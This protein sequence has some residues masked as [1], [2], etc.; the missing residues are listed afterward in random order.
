MFLI[1]LAWQMMRFNEAVERMRA[2]TAIKAG[3]Q[4]GEQK[5][6]EKRLQGYKESFAAAFQAQSTQHSTRQAY[7][8]WMHR[9]YDL[10]MMQLMGFS[11]AKPRVR[12]QQWSDQEVG[13]M[14]QCLADLASG[15]DAIHTRDPFYYISHHALLRQKSNEEVKALLKFVEKNY[16]AQ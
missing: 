3:T 4:G 12:S 8:E 10:E 14:L 16:S 15:N 11:E 1:L 9:T 6:S 5:P 2:K 7:H 13:A